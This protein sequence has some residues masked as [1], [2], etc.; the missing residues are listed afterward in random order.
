MKAAWIRH[1]CRGGYQ[2][3]AGKARAE[4]ALV[5]LDPHSVPLAALEQNQLHVATSQCIGVLVG[6]RMNLAARK[7]L[8]V[9]GDCDLRGR[10][11]LDPLLRAKE[12][13][14][15]PGKPLGQQQVARR[16]AAQPRFA[17]RQ[18]VKPGDREPTVFGFQINHPLLPPLD[19]FLAIG[20]FIARPG[21]AHARG[22]VKKHQEN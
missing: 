13:T 3:Q 11:E 15:E 6:I 16:F 4:G 19:N 20:I 10:L 17:R 8:A 14:E 18:P 9:A 12:R 5:V 21:R 7:R 22:T 1:S 2:L